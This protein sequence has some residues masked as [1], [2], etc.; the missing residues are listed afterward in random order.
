MPILRKHDYHR[1][2]GERC[3]R[4]LSL[5]RARPGAMLPAEL[6]RTKSDEETENY[7]VTRLLGNVLEAICDFDSFYEARRFQFRNKIVKQLN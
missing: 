1:T 2:L 7:I 3:T 5:Q 4:N 6:L